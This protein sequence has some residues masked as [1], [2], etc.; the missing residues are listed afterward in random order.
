MNSALYRI[1]SDISRLLPEYEITG[2]PVALKGGNLNFI[3]RIPA[4]PH[5]VIVKKA[6]PYIASQP[7]IPLDPERILFEGWALALFGS[8]GPLNQLTCDNVRPPEL[9][10]TDETKHLL[11]MEDF[12]NLPNLSEWLC[13][14]DPGDAAERLGGFIGRLHL[15]TFG[16][17]ELKKSFNNKSIQQTRYDLQY[18]GAEDMLNS[19]GIADF[20]ILGDEI[21]ELGKKF[22]QPGICLTMGDLW[23]PSLLMGRETTGLIDWEFC[24]YGDP[25]QDVGHLQAHLWMQTQCAPNAVIA[26]RFKRFRSDFLDTYILT[27]KDQPDLWNEPIRR[28]ISLHAAA[29]ILARTMGS[30]RE[31]YLYEGLDA[32]HSLMREAVETAAEW[33]RHPLHG[34][35]SLNG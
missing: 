14:N 15:R 12:G 7:D 33:I 20:G 27:V 26:K 22:L 5:N 18:D 32:G 34:L 10:A 25:A 23:P 17:E 11:I 29:E 31:G 30:F 6:P 4:K 19:A 13:E 8:G 1:T 3:W 2:Q 9:Y 28:D 24:H 35:N 21:R 16:N